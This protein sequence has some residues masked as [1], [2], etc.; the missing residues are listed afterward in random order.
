MKRIKKL[1]VLTMASVTILGLF[2][3]GASASWKQDNTGWW[4][5]EGSSYATGWKQI[6]ENWYYFDNNGYMVHDTTVNGFVV[7]SNGIW[8]NNDSTQ[9]TNT[10]VMV[11]IFYKLDDLKVDRMIQ[12]I[13]SLKA[14][15]GD[16]LSKKSEIEDTY[17]MIIINANDYNET[18]EGLM[19]NTMVHGK[20]ILTNDN[21]IIKLIEK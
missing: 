9:I 15:Y 14:Y 12:G 7:N 18:V 6:D 21:G 10:K 20:Y 4:Y 5:T 2:T 11:S 13:Q 8:I 17:G 16:N 19:E 3:I 1:A